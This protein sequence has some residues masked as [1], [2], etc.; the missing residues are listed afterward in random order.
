MEYNRL[1]DRKAETERIT[2]ALKRENTQF[3][4]IYGRRRIGKSTLIKYLV[5]CQEQAIYFLSDSSTEAVQRDAFW[6]QSEKKQKGTLPHQRL[7]S[8]IPL[9]IYR[10]LSFYP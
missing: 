9:S 2:E 4:V 1:I 3:I 7:T 10:A 6:R 8:Q 5:N